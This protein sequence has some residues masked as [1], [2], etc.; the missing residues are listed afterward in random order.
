MGNT[1][2]TPGAGHHRPRVVLSVVSH[3]QGWLVGG[4]LSDIARCWD[5]SGLHLVLTQ[6]LPESEPPEL[7]R[8]PFPVRVIRN[9]RPRGFAANHNSAF[10]VYESDVFCVVNPDVRCPEDP[11]GPLVAALADPLTALAAPRIVDP[12]GRLEDSV[13]RRITPLRLLKRAAGLEKGPDYPVADAPVY[14]DW[15]AGMFMALRSSVY[16]ELAGFDERYRLYCEDADLCMRLWECGYRVAVVPEAWVVHEARRDS[17][18]DLQLMR[19]HV[20]SLLRFFA[21]YPLERRTG[22]Q[23]QQRTGKA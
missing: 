12:R 23:W 15:V 14:P 13:R 7:P 16:P 2:T 11:V 3:G 4:L 18:R 17:H 22:G 1:L 20:A 8:L 21:R 19:W 9:L 10:Q 5:H 6:N